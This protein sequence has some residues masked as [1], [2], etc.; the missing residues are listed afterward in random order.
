MTKCQG[1]KKDK[2]RCIYEAKIN[3]YCGIHIKSSFCKICLKMRTSYKKC[4]L[5]IIQKNIK[6]IKPLILCN[7]Y[8]IDCWKSIL[9]FCDSKT[10]LKIRKLDKY[11]YENLVPTY[12]KGYVPFF[13]F[14]SSI[15]KLKTINCYVSKD[16]ARNI[17]YFQNLKVLKCN[18]NIDQEYNYKNKTFQYKDNL[19]ILNNITLHLINLVQLD[20]EHIENV[21]LTP[22]QNLVSVKSLYK[23]VIIVNNN[24]L[25]S[26]DMCYYTELP[27]SIKEICIKNNP[28][29]IFN[30]LKNKPIDGKLEVHKSIKGLKLKK[31]TTLNIYDYLDISDEDL[32]YLTVKMI[33]NSNYISNFVNLK[34]LHLNTMKNGNINNLNKLE[35][36]KTNISIDKF[37][38]CKNLKYLRIIS[39]NNY[40]YYDVNIT[41][42]NKLET[43]VTPLYRTNTI[44]SYPES[45][46]NLSIPIE[47]I[48]NIDLNKYPNIKTLKII[49]KKFSIFKYNNIFPESNYIE[50]LILTCSENLLKFNNLDCYP[51]LKYISYNHDFKKQILQVIKERNIKIVNFDKA[52]KIFCF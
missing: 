5:C 38:N 15:K 10:Y 17:K 13:N 35:R 32:E 46:Q 51:K 45:M 31:L 40:D 23:N 44:F 6:N 50:K 37:S 7:Y 12:I 28:R 47:N 36:L 14:A 39:L 30:I 8:N 1:T 52:N 16:F 48:K 4:Y 18:I 43:L 34:Y 33:K 26:I 22:L 24:K 3:N 29:N 25:I 49:Y 41:I 9:Q 11:F 42:F 19:R 27:K 21:D 20:C 2:K